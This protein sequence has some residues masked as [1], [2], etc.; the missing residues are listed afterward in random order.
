M[1]GF[2]DWTGFDV[3][4]F[5][6]EADV[7]TGGAEEFGF[8]EDAGEPERAAAAGRFGHEGDAGQ[9]AERRTV[10]LVDFA[11]AINVIPPRTCPRR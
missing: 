7:F 5:E 4:F 2:P 8:D 11:P 1:H 3:F 6:G 9:V 10:I